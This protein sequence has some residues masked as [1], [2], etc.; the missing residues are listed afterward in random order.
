M[1]NAPTCIGVIVVTFI[2]QQ[3]SQSLAATGFGIEPDILAQVADHLHQ[4]VVPIPFDGTM[5]AGRRGIGAEDEPVGID[6]MIAAELPHD[7]KRR[8]DH[9]LFPADQRPG[10]EAQ[11]LRQCILTHPR[12]A[13]D[14]LDASSQG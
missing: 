11:R 10:G 2:A 12:H 7:A 13:T 9:V 3:A 4:P 1:T 8:F 6:L 5:I 14:R